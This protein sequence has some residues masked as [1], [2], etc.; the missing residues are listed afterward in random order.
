MMGIR[1]YL[2]DGFTWKR[3][4]RRVG[5]GQEQLYPPQTH[6]AS[7]H[8][9][10]LFCSSHIFLVEFVHLEHTQTQQQTP[11]RGSQT[12]RFRLLSSGCFKS[13][14]FG[15]SLQNRLSELIALQNNGDFKATIFL[16]HSGSS[17]IQAT[18]IIITHLN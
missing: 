2:S 3:V 1:W 16:Y 13:T 14:G 12:G 4:E 6:T 18:H 9:I 15:H 11:T 7:K 8:F 10:N 17:T 5:T